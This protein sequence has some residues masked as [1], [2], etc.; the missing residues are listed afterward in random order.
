MKKPLTLLLHCIFVMVLGFNRLV[1]AAELVIRLE[2]PPKKG[3][4]VFALFDSVNAFG[5][6]RDPVMM[7]S[8]PL[9]GRAEY[10]VDDVPAGEYA[11]LVYS[12][13]NGN[14]RIDKNFIGIPKEPLGFSNSYRP[15]GP[16]SYSRAVFTLADAESKDFDV[17][18]YRPLGKRG[19]L[20][21]GVGLIARTTPYRDYDGGVYQ[22]IPAVT[23]VGER[24]QVYG[25]NLQVSLLGSGNMRLAAT[26]RYRIGVYEEDKSPFLA[27][28]GDRKGTFMAGLSVWTKVYAGVDVSVRYEHDVIDRIGGGEMRFEIAKSFHAGVFRIS[29]QVA[30]NWLSADMSIHDFGVP[31]KKETSYRPAYA[32]DDT[33]SFEAGVSL[34][35]EVTRDWLVVSKIG[36]ELLDREVRGSPIVA[37]DYVV[38]G[39][40]A[41]SY[42]F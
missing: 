26:G 31:R 14:R 5:D 36:I 34:L 15:K 39:F 2:D 23:Y 38:K 10:V 18:L 6:L 21:V 35:I 41:I 17:E 16:P 29:P 20:G 40:M 24:L 4:V 32:I 28:L 37:D 42:L 22:F 8:F 19:R 3:I 9:D 30:M 25:P 33:L 12:D 1:D 7:V 11:L 27:G 13:E